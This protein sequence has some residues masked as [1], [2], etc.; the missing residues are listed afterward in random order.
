MKK[1]ISITLVL[2]CYFM[3]TS[4]KANKHDLQDILEVLKHVETNYDPTKIGDNGDALGI[5]QIHQGCITDVNR[6]YGTKY[7]HEDAINI[8]N[9]EDIFIKYISIGI[10]IYKKKHNHDPTEKQIVRMWNGGIY[11][12]YKYKSTIPYVKKYIK[13]KNMLNN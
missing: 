8:S 2:L 13:Q 10:K 4:F 7:I 6:Y 3:I 12:G 5:L 11:K 1:V 9:S